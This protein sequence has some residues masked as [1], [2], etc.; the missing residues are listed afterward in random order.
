MDKTIYK[1][2]KQIEKAWGVEAYNELCNVIW[3]QQMKIERL[4]KSRKLWREKYY[5]EQ[6]LQ[7]QRNMQVQ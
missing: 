3:K 7:I 1:Q 4:E 2:L 5:N 6:Q